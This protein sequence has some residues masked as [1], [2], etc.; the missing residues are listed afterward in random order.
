MKQPEGKNMEIS[1]QPILLDNNGLSLFM[2]IPK[3]VSD[4]L[5]MAKPVRLEHGCIRHMPYIVITTY[6][7]AEI[8]SFY[9]VKEPVLLRL[10]FPDN[11]G[12]NVRLVCHDHGIIHTEKTGIVNP[13]FSRGFLADVL[14]Y[15]TLD[16]PNKPDILQ[17]I[18]A[19]YK[20]EQLSSQC[21]NQCVIM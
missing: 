19:T 3:A 2:E 7:G 18:Y 17:S 14:E 5:Q 21:K 6:A 1:R 15:Y 13:M 8:I 9:Q 10:N 12:L 16:I 4:I 20:A 11:A